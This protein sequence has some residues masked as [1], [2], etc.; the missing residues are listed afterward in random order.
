[1]NQETAFINATVHTVDPRDI[2]TQVTS[3]G[4]RCAEI[5]GASLTIGQL[6]H[7]CGVSRRQ[8]EVA[9]AQHGAS[10]AAYLRRVPLEAARRS[11]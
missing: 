9:F 11:P 3:E 1:M 10:P 8:L 6:A 4:G 7:Q 2:V 5:L